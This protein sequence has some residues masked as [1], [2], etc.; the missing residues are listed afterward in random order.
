MLAIIAASVENASVFFIGALALGLLMTWRRTTRLQR[1]LA[2]FRTLVECGGHA[3]AVPTTAP[4]RPAHSTA[5]PP[6]PAP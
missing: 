5:R 4:A 2:E 3:A 1:E 6:A